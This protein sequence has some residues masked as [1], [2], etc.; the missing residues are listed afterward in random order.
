MANFE[1]DIFEMKSLSNIYQKP[2]LEKTANNN[3]AFSV[4]RLQLFSVDG[5]LPVV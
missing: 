4:S 2:V 1:H 5:R 3:P